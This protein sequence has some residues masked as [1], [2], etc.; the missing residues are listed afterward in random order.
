MIRAL[1]D[2]IAG[3]RVR[4]A[5]LFPG[6]RPAAPRPTPGA[7]DVRVSETGFPSLLA[8]IGLQAGAQ[9]PA[10]PPPEAGR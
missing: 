8:A 3:R 10:G 9:P 4:L 7:A 2:R 1:R 5:R 6:A